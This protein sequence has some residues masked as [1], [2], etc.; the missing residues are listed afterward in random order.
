M[1]RLIATDLDGSLLPDDK[2]VPEDFFTLLPELKK[3]GIYFFAASGRTHQALT[4]NF[5][6]VSEQIGY[7]CENG[8]YVVH[9]GNI[10][11]S[12]TIKA[13]EISE[14]IK[15]VHMLPD[16]HLVLCGKK[17]AYMTVYPKK[18]DPHMESYH[19]VH[20]TITDYH[21]VKDDFFK[22]A[23]CDLRGPE[24]NSFPVLYEKFGKD[25]GMFISGKHWMDIMVKG[26]NK[27]QALSKVQKRLG[28]LRE[29]TLAFGD[30]Y[31]DIELLKQAGYGYVMKN[32]TV[33]MKK[34]AKYVTSHTNN[35]NGV[36]KVVKK[37]LF[38][39]SETQL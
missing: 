32:A 18:F 4:Q 6:P 36:I 14:I 25:F 8:A 1:I 38:G 22:L 24:N 12:S 11:F 33:D 37:F 28:I 9:D 34:N 20:E 2:K 13:I 35:E 17:T 31:N 21:S 23:I 30:Y 27:G 29:E 26:V 15:T 19:A 3:R 7:I 16:V 5:S 10:L 39:Q